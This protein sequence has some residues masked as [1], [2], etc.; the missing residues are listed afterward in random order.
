MAEESRVVAEAIEVVSA[1]QDDKTRRARVC[2]CGSCK[3]EAQSFSEWLAGPP[4][5]TAAPPVR[6]SWWK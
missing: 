3:N 5:P 2:G 6:E 1:L 4:T